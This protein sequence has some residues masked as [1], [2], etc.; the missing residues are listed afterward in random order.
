M[1]N[2]KHVQLVLV[3]KGVDVVTHWHYEHPGSRLDLS[4]ANLSWQPLLD[5]D[6]VL[7]DLSGA[8]LRGAD[9]RGADLRGAILVEANFA[10]T[11]L[12]GALLSNADLRR[13][14]LTGAILSGAILEEANLNE[15]DLSRT[16]LLGAILIGAHLMKA[17]LMQADLSRTDLT[18]ADLKEA[19]FTDATFHYV[20]L[21]HVNLSQ[22]R[23]LASVAHHGPSSVGID[24]LI[25]SYQ[26]AG[27]RLTL[28]LETFLR[29]AGVP[30]ELLD[31]LPRI[32]GEV[33]YC[34]CFLCYGEPD[35]VF[36]EKL[37]DNLVAPGVSCWLYSM[38]A[39]PG[40]RTWREIGDKRRG[41][42]KMVVLC[43]AQALI[44]DG[45]LKEIEEQIDEEPNKMVP[46]SLDNLWKESGFRIMR[47]NR[48]LKPFLLER[49]Y[50]DFSGEASYRE[51]LER[52][53]RGLE[54]KQI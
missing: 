28:E 14:N 34:S 6:L 26:G 4:G 33:K 23:G 18:S 17:N 54:R 44:R 27:N 13:A 31:A 8:D 37:R 41:A 35:K 9:L 5:A 19:D 7:A 21:A 3:N 53:L 48:D 42:E 20:S 10:G 1:A 40:E 39:T 52:L 50:A 32:V 46:V 43:S 12:A 24:T 36:A 45:V 38:D 16:D 11:K 29:G 47:G 51:T 25:A 49:N 15:A 2:P 30:K 22:A